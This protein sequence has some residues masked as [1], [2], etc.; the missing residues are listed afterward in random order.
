MDHSLTQDPQKTEE[1][2]KARA[3]EREFY[4]EFLDRLETISLVNIP[5]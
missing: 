2:R 5:L 4:E 3:K 1:V